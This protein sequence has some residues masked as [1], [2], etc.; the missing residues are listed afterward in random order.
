MKWLKKDTGVR[1]SATGSF[2]WK[3]IRKRIEP[4]AAILMLAFGLLSNTASADESRFKSVESVREV[5]L[6]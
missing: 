3:L 1:I 6:E 2:G 5:L 4:I